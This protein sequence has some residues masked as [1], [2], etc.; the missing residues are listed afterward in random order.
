M[1]G[2][3][4]TTLAKVMF[5]WSSEVYAVPYDMYH[6]VGP[7]FYCSAQLRPNAEYVELLLRSLLLLL[8]SNFTTSAP[9]RL[10]FDG[11]KPTFST[12][13]MWD[14]CPIVSK[15][16]IRNFKPTFNS[17]RPI[18]IRRALQCLD[19]EELEEYRDKLE[20][21]YRILN[22]LPD[23]DP[24]SLKNQ[25]AF[26]CANGAGTIDNAG[27]PFDIHFGWLFHPWHRW[28][29]YFHERIL[30]SVLGDPSFTLHFWNWDND[31]IVIN[32]R[33]KGCTKSGHKFPSMYA[34][35]S[36][37]L[38]H[39]SRSPGLDDPSLLVDLGRTLY[40]KDGET[41]LPPGP[42]LPDDVVLARNTEA[43]AFWFN[44]DSST[45]RFYGR[46]YRA[47][48]PKME[49]FSVTIGGSL[50][51]YAHT[52]VHFWVQGDM[53]LTGTAAYDPVFY[54]HH[55]N[56]ERLWEHWM[57]QA[58]DRVPE[59]PDFLDAELLFFDENGDTVRVRVGD[60]LD[61]HLLGYDYE[62]TNDAS[63]NDPILA[64]ITLVTL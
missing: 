38:Y 51:V 52:S 37:P 45:R 56:I 8:V 26:H 49:D 20:T 33:S 36:S 7:C 41:L 1:G 50:E 17:S 3:G 54:A 47:G 55:G 14:C 46:A 58:P 30:Q 19:E 43:M 11:C 6:A 15:E 13:Q 44:G 59:D 12:G 16:P 63:W 24:R 31:G 39:Q 34:D 2:V 4:K 35:P 29:L 18:R 9:V 22:A 42:Q 23:D 60:V 32:G 53:A 10:T 5:K 40:F 57:R 25:A 27:V 62:E 64:G 21:A 48:D 61:T 28:F